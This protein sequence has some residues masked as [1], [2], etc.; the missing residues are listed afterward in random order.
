MLGLICQLKVVLGGTIQVLPGVKAPHI[1][2]VPIDVFVPPSLKSVVTK[3]TAQSKTEDSDIM[4]YEGRGCESVFHVF[5]TMELPVNVSQ[6]FIGHVGVYL[7]RSYILVS[8]E[9]L[10]G[11]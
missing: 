2:V 6:A 8:Q 10:N 5:A 4:V 3:I 11:P 9:F 7:G 1:L